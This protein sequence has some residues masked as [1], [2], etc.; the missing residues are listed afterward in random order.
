MGFS[1]SD[2][3]IMISSAPGKRSRCSR[4]FAMEDKLPR[5]TYFVNRYFRNDKKGVM[6]NH[7]VAAKLDTTD[8]INSAINQS[9]SRRTATFNATVF[10]SKS[11]AKAFFSKTFTH[12]RVGRGYVHENERIPAGSTRRHHRQYSQTRPARASRHLRKSDRR[13]LQY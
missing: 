4:V 12:F 2:W 1:R 11:K 13:P 6:H 5:N 3:R 9:G 7:F 8:I 10:Y